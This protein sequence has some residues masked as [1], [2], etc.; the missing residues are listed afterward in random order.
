MLG[1]GEGIEALAKP[2]FV[3]GVSPFYGRRSVPPPFNGCDTAAHK[4]TFVPL[5]FY[6]GTL[7]LKIHCGQY[8]GDECRQR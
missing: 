4:E 5:R 6:G 8:C 3:R 7:P 1:T 2:I